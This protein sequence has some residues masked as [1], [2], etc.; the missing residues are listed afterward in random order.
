MT[1]ETDRTAR[2]DHERIFGVDAI[3]GRWA[4]VG[5]GLL[6]NLCLGAIYAFSVFKRPLIEKWAISDTASGFPFMVFLAA[7]AVFM[8][9]A[10]PWITKWGPRKTGLIGATVVGVGWLLSGIA[11]NI[12]V[13]TAFYGG[14]AGAGVG[15]LYGC[16][17]ATVTKWFPDHRGFAVGLTVLGFGVSAL[18]TAPLMTALIENAGVLQT[19]AILGGVF[20]VLLLLLVSPFRFPSERWTPPPGSTPSGKPVADVVE[21]DRGGMVRRRTFY[22]LWST[23]TIGSLAGLMA[24]GFS[25][26]FGTDVA[27]LAGSLATIAVAV[28]AVFNGVGRPIFGW[29]VD[30]RSPRFAA[31]TSFALVLLASVL[32]YFWGQGNTAVYFIAF[33]LLWMTLG[34]WVAIAPAATAKLFGPKYYARNYAVVFSAYGVGAILGTVLSGMIKD[35]LGSY[36]PVF[37]PVMGLAA[38]GFLISVTWLK[39]VRR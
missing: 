28:F 27:G 21:I 34:G 11:P 32:L 26:D 29:L 39:P 24:I 12:W 10:G 15:I 33:C 2:S 13:L 18:V 36:L 16:P 9:I 35:A 6:I 5:L 30:E 17:I 37:L 25:K 38:L 19:F 8:A 3:H 7:F 14:I 4:F 1:T 20:L 22:A 23:F 31:A